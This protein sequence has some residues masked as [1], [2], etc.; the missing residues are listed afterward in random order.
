MKKYIV[1][2]L[3]ITLPQTLLSQVWNL[4]FNEFYQTVITEI[5][6]TNDNSFIISGLCMGCYDS[7]QTSLFYKDV[8]KYIK[9]ACKKAEINE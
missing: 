1:L 5:K 7:E 6:R 3:I 9:S 2:T 8:N 4:D